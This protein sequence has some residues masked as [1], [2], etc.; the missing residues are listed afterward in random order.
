MTGAVADLEQP[1]LRGA[2]AAG[3]PVAAVLTRAGSFVNST[4]SSSSQWIALGRLA[5]QH[6]DELAVGRLVRGA[7]DILGVLLGRVLRRRTR[8]GSRPAP[9]RSCSPGASPWSRPRP[10]RRSA[11]RR[12]PRRGPRPRCRSRARRRDRL[13]G[14]GR[15]LPDCANQ[16]N[17]ERLI[18]RSS[19][20]SPRSRP[21]WPDG[22]SACSPSA[23]PPSRRPPAVSSSGTSKSARH[24][25]PP[26]RASSSTFAAGSSSAPIAAPK[27]ATASGRDRRVEAERGRQRERVHRPVR[28]AERAAERLRHRVPER[29]PG[30]RERLAGG[31][32]TAK[33]PGAR[34]TVVRRLDHARQPG[35]RSAPRPRARTRRSPPCAC[36]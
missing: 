36:P 7:P 19:G 8:P 29:E 22:G 4:P 18:N 31:G 6:L 21:A 33:E 32:R 10:G 28:E 5:G 30:E 1:L 3:E 14:H 9:S 16:T 25:K 23:R 24:S 26:S 17:Q 2:A 27:R 15:T 13:A 35:R 20:A 12:R 34:L 11:P